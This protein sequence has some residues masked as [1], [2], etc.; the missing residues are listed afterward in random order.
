MVTWGLVKPRSSSWPSKRPIHIRFA[1][2]HGTRAGQAQAQLGPSTSAWHGLRR[3]GGCCSV[4]TDAHFRVHPRVDAALILL[5]ALFVLHFSRRSAGGDEVAGLQP[6][7][8]RRHL[9]K[10]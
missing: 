9:R 10:A 5:D 7:A 1:P 6:G 8:F 3:T 4:L 2:D